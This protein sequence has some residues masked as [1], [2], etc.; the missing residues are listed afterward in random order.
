[1]FFCESPTKIGGNRVFFRSPLRSPL[2]A[3]DPAGCKFSNCTKKPQFNETKAG[4][5]FSL[6]K[7]R[8]IA[9]FGLSF[10][11]TVNNKKKMSGFPLKP[12]QKYGQLKIKLIHDVK[13]DLS[14]F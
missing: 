14:F 4:F 3:L 11:K 13:E 12:V 10:T 7:T 6:Q 8:E 2:R 9:F 5:K 1:M